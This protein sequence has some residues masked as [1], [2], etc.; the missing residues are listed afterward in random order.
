MGERGRAERDFDGPIF[1]RE[2]GATRATAQYLSDSVNRRVREIAARYRC[3]FGP[4]FSEARENAVAV[5]LAVLG[6][7][8]TAIG[9]RLSLKFREKPTHN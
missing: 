5:S 2:T 8:A 3:G 4:P 9:A 7:R 6:S 1:R